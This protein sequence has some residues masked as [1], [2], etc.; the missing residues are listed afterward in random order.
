MKRK[1]QKISPELRRAVFARDNYTCRYCGSKEGPF[2]CD[3]VYPEVKG[4]E[5]SL[6]NLVTACRNCNQEK[7]AKLGVWPNPPGHF[8]RHKVLYPIWAILAVLFIG[9]VVAFFISYYLLPDAR[10]IAGLLAAAFFVCSLGLGFWR[11]TK[12]ILSR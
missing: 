12:S 1:K 4:G 6:N 5:T 10:Y 2:H 9:A 11:T 3:H 7:H 8:D